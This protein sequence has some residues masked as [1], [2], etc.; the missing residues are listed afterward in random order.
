MMAG[1]LLSRWLPYAL[2]RRGLMLAAALVAILGC[3]ITG[4]RYW[5]LGPLLAASFSPRIV[6]ELTVAIGRASG[7]PR[8]IN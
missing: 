5:L 8:R 2:W 3:I 6:G 7:N 4:F 1:H